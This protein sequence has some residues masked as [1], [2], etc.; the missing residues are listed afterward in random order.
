MQDAPNKILSSVDT[1]KRTYRNLLANLKSYCVLCYVVLFPTFIYQYFLP[2]EI[3]PNTTKF[4]DIAPPLF[5][6][7]IILVIF[8][9]FLFRLIIIGSDGQLKL[10][11]S[12][13]LNMVSRSF[14]YSMA[15]AMVLVIAL[16]SVGLLFMLLLVI[17]NSVAGQNATDT[18]LVST[19]VW[20]GI[21]IFLM[22]IVFRTLPTFISIAI[23]KTTIP[24]KSA[25]YYTR[26][27]TKNFLII[28]IFC[29]LPFTI[30]SAI[31]VYIIGFTGIE[32]EMVNML[33]SFIL[34]PI[35][36]APY[37]LQLSAGSELYKELVPMD[38][39]LNINNTDNTV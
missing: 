9:I 36:I 22:L 29:Y 15:L 32:N 19:I 16:L 6:T 33:I 28:G 18:N 3:D 26:D 30:I 4:I 34:T 37:A 21:S 7:L 2:L 24:M 39:N 12:T 14:L 1:I 17:I 11:A 23:G 27:N 13:L 20:V 5:L 25:Y 8:S 10:S 38:D 35:S 31:L